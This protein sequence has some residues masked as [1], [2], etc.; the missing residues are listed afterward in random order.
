MIGLQQKR[1]WIPLVVVLALLAPL[2]WS[3]DGSRLPH[4]FSGDEPHYL[5]SIHSV[6]L[7]RDLDLANNYA[8]VH[9]GATH[10]G[11]SFAGS[12]LDH[13]SVWFENGQRRNWE[14][15]Y[16]RKP[17]NFDRDSNGHPTP[18]LQLG[19]I[20]PLSGHPE[21]SQHPMGMALLLAPA[22][23]PIRHTAYVEP[24]AIVCTSI[25]VVAA[26]FL[27]RALLRKYTVSGPLADLVAMVAILGTPAWHYARTLFTEPYLL[28]FAVATYSFG[29][30]G[31]PTLA[32]MAIALG[33]LMK[34]PFALLAL[35]L[36]AMYAIERDSSATLRLAV[37]IA[38]SIAVLFYLNYLMFGSL[39]VAAQ[40][41]L[42][43]S[44]IRGTGGIL[45]SPRYGLLMVAPAFLVAV[46]AW[47]AFFRHH[48][49]DA[50]IIGIGFVLYFAIAAS[51]KYWNGAT[52]Y[53][54]R[55]VMPVIPLLFVSLVAL[56]RSAIW[57]CR[58]A[59][60]LMISICVVSIIINGFAAIPY[61]SSFDTNPPIRFVQ[62]LR[63][64]FS[65]ITER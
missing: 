58:G 46:A 24:I 8:A 10:A 45:F 47:P 33:V 50:V 51:W 3:K 15:V 5:L 59:R 29:L 43:G 28:L 2:L 32:G 25:A 40:A 22:L 36:F 1:S 14:T 20:E 38:V 26:F 13:Q 7:D 48:R 53:A 44:I 6:I 4:I 41:W 52:A 42:H 30:R 11:Q 37:P 12:A 65:Q 57:S 17:E 27:L 19:A 64:S 39:L 35:P 21:Y 61:W 54:A 62:F 49:R 18:R 56:P 60:V 23:Y 16:E 9:E 55:I 63:S 31:F 34:P